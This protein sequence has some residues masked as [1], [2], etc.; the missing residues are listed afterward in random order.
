M[1]N[2]K[3]VSKRIIWLI[4]L[5]SIILFLVIV[6]AFGLLNKSNNNDKKEYNYGTITLGFSDSNVYRFSNLSPVSEEVG[7]KGTDYF[8]FNVNTLL[9]DSSD[10]DYEIAI[11]IDSS[12]SNVDLDNLKFYLE[13]EDSGSYNKVFGPDLF[14]GLTSASVLGTPKDSMILFSDNTDENKTVNYRLRVWLD[15]ASVVTDDGEHYVTVTVDVYG[16]GK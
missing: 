16:K 9:E 3:G 10:I 12:L 7:K 4:V 13:R 6:L 8:E 15:E 2:E 11:S 1:K 14:N 5:I